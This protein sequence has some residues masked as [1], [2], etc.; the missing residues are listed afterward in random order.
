MTIVPN[1]C[2]SK[3]KHCAFRDKVYAEIRGWGDLSVPKDERLGSWPREHLPNLFLC[4]RDTQDTLPPIPS[5]A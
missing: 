4:S 3:G 5:P 1:F 2:E